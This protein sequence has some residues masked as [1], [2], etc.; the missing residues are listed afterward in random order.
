MKCVNLKILIFLILFGS[1]LSL[2]SE[3]SKNYLTQHKINIG[4]NFSLPFQF[5]ANGS[6]V[7]GISASPQL[8]YFILDDFEIF[9]RLTASGELSKSDSLIEPRPKELF[10][11]FG[12]GF[13]YYFQASSNLYPYVGAAWNMSGPSGNFFGDS[14]LMIFDFPVGVLFFVNQNIALNLALPFKMHWG[15]LSGLDKFSF[16]LPTIGV[17]AYF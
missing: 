7:I 8:G 10:F 2:F 15:T 4:G 13:N 16:D 3:E 14:M 12:V 6:Y 11:G 17:S 9:G 1:S 5:K